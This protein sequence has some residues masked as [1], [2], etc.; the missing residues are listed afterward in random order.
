MWSNQANCMLRSL[1]RDVAPVV[2]P[3]VPAE[4]VQEFIAYAKAKSEKNS[5]AQGAMERLPICARA[6]RGPSQLARPLVNLVTDRNVRAPTVR[7]TKTM[8]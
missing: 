2:Q 8:T 5:I 4:T 7:F 1:N 6:C 3:S